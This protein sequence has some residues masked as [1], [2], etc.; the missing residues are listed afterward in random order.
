MTSNILHIYISHEYLSPFRVIYDTSEADFL[1]SAGRRK[2]CLLC[3]DYQIPLVLITKHHYRRSD[4]AYMYE[5]KIYTHI[6]HNIIFCVY[7]QKCLS[8]NVTKKKTMSQTTDLTQQKPHIIICKHVLRMVL[9]VEIL[10]YL[11]HK[12]LQQNNP[13]CVSSTRSSSNQVKDMETAEAI[14]YMLLRIRYE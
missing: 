2:V 3:G 5:G 14:C 6:R 7:Y 4:A 11:H 9:H 13:G 8:V 12:L 1:S 10:Q